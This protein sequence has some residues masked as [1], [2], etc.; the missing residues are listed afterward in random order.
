MFRGLTT[1]GDVVV[2]ATFYNPYSMMGK[3]WAHGF[4][5]RRTRE[6][7]H[8]VRIGSDGF[9]SHRYRIDGAWNHSKYERGFSIRLGPLDSNNLRVVMI[10]AEGWV[11]VNGRYQGN[12]DLGSVT[13][14]GSIG[15]FADDKSYGET[16]FEDFRVWR[17]GPSLARQLPDVGVVPTPTPTFG[18]LAS[19]ASRVSYDDLF[20]NNH[21]HIGKVVYYEGEVVQVIEQ[22]GNV[23]ALRVKVTKDDYYWKDTL[24]LHYSGPRVL[25]E[26]IIEFV[27]KVVG[28]Y[29][30]E[31][32][33][34]ASIT[35]PKVTMIQ[36][37]LV[38]KA[39]ER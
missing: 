15:A 25:E 30:Y 12:L 20:R 6:G 24:Y 13:K 3:V 27:G 36:Y 28:L 34:G 1:D 37:R 22:E 8:S 16:R 31:S 17:Y 39:S 4:L 23:R 9:W 29:T 14:G 32:V 35:I 10:G 21:R 18:D 5:L 7:V 19:S 2:E 33:S 26:D 11:Y 38:T